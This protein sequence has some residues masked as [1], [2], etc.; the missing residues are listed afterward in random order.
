VVRSEGL[1]VDVAP[2]S[3]LGRLD[4]GKSLRA[5]FRGNTGR[6]ATT[7]RNEPYGES[8]C[9]NESNIRLRV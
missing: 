1:A 4:G 5:R 8:K 9:R 2:V 7:V 6:F 3:D